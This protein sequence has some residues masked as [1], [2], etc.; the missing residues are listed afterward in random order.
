MINSSSSSTIP[1][2]PTKR[3]ATSRSARRANGVNKALRMLI[4][5]GRVPV[6]VANE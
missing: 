2:I 3:T 5:E 4:E 1:N 6:R